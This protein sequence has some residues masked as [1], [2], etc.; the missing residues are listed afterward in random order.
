MSSQGLER[1]RRHSHRGI[2]SMLAL[3]EAGI[4]RRTVKLA[5]EPPGQRFGFVLPAAAE[6]ADPIVFTAI[7]D[8]AIAGCGVAQQQDGVVPMLA[9]DIAHTLNR[10]VR[11]ATHAQLGATMRRVRYRFLPKLKPSDF[12]LVCAGS[13]DV[14]AKRKPE[15]WTDDLCAVLDG[16]L[17]QCPRVVLC[18]AG[19]MFLS[20]VLKPHLRAVLDEKIEQ[21]SIISREI[22]AQKG[23]A[24][25]N[26]ASRELSENYW[27]GD[28]FHPGPQGYR[29]AADIILQALWAKFP[30][31]QS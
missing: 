5:P 8:S 16:A 20:P 22:C 18:S 17:A 21:Q 3:I 4:A 25:A 7:G 28:G 11:W 2:T 14:L 31:N 13:N 10:Q 27:A 23:V 19:P 6:H 9:N 12:A 29:L 15:E 1:M 24:F 26:V 30:A